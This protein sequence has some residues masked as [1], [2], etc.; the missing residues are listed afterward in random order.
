MLNKRKASSRNGTRPICLDP[1]VMDI[2]AERF[3]ICNHGF[4]AACWADY[5]ESSITACLRGT[6]DENTL[7]AILQCELHITVGPECPVCRTKSPMIHDLAC[8]WNSLP[9]SL[10]EFSPDFCL[11]LATNKRPLF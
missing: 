7:A 10:I 4:H 1:L 6:Q 11:K 5:V 9:D 3:T 8:N 2:T